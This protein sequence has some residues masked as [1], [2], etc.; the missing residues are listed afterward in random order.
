MN[1][2]VSKRAFRT[3]GSEIWQRSRLQG[4]LFLTL[5][6]PFLGACLLLLSNGELRDQMFLVLFPMQVL[7]TPFIVA[8]TNDSLRRKYLLPISTAQLVATS[9][10]L[11]LL[12]ALIVSVITT[13][14]TALICTKMFP[15]VRPTLLAMSLVPLALAV[16]W[17]FARSRG[18][19]L[20]VGLLAF[21]AALTMMILGLQRRPESILEPAQF[22]ADNAKLFIGFG[23][24]YFLF[25]IW[26][27]WYTVRLD[28]QGEGPAFPVWMKSFV[29][30]KSQTVPSAL[31]SNRDGML[32]WFS[33]TAVGN[34][35]SCFA[36]AFMSVTAIAGILWMPGGVYSFHS[37]IWPRMFT[38]TLVVEFLLLAFITGL[39]SAILENQTKP[40]KRM[41]LY[42]NLPMS[43]REIATATLTAGIRMLIPIAAFAVIG[44]LIVVLLFRNQQ[45]ATFLAVGPATIPFSTNLTNMLIQIAGVCLLGWTVFGYSHWALGSGRPD[46]MLVLMGSIFLGLYSLVFEH[47]MGSIGRSLR[48]IVLVSFLIEIVLGSIWVCWKTHQLRMIDRR[49]FKRMAAGWL[50]AFIF[51]MFFFW[52]TSDTTSRNVHRVFGSWGWPFLA[53]LSVSIAFLAVLPIPGS[54]LAVYWNRHQ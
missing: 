15:I 26:F 25:G 23:S 2:L 22:F 21:S 6:V 9:I 35:F 43:D 14:L 44:Q 7:W 39:R 13:L 18:L 4:W 5:M 32:Q 10:I 53:G 34:Q 3:F 51:C 38:G 52:M 45:L 49:D 46:V 36:I 42:G 31:H 47:F 40:N 50:L 37:E 30:R 54:R 17:G 48:N 41:I 19:Q 24:S 28:R 20:T 27:T 8:A 12:A 1:S 16:H 29:E 11:N 33:M